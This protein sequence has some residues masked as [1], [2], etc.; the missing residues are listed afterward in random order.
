M[1]AKIGARTSKAAPRGGRATVFLVL[2]VSVS[3]ARS[4]GFVGMTGK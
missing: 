1:K 3:G 2:R 4:E